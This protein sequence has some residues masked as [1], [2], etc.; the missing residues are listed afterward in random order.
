M[1]E[2]HASAWASVR[3]AREAFELAATKAELGSWSGNADEQTAAISWI[4]TTN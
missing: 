2:A 3:A 4:Q 1:S